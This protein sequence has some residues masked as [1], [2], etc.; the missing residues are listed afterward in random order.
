MEYARLTS[1]W[2]FENDFKDSVGGHDGTAVADPLMTPGFAAG[3]IG[4]YALSF[5]G[6][7]D[8]LLL[9]PAALSRAGTEMTFAFWAKNNTPTAGTMALYGYAAAAPG[10]RI[11]NIH[12]P[13]SNNTAFL[14]VSNSDAAGQVMIVSA[15]PMRWSRPAIRTGCTGS[16]PK[17]WRP[18]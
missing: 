1:Q 10:N 16:L 6:V 14:D 7:D 17:T 13:W 11:V 8:Y 12:T 18:A 5:D 3:K 15:P 2:A 9:P 4:D